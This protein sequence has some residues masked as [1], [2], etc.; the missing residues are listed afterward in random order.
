[1]EVRD[2]YTKNSKTLVKETEDNTNK[3]IFYAHRL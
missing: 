1:M 2:L 3:K